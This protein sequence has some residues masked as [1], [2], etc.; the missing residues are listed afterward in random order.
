MIFRHGV[1]VELACLATPISASYTI[2]FK[3]DLISRIDTKFIASNQWLP[4]K[5]LEQAVSQTAPEKY[6]QHEDGRRK[7]QY[8]TP[9]PRPNV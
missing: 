8:Q 5:A 7:Q 1:L 2:F 9:R 4:A 3:S 6:Q